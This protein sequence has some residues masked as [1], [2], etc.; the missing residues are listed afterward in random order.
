VNFAVGLRYWLPGPVVRGLY[1]QVGISVYYTVNS[2]V[3]N[4]VSSR[5]NRGIREILG[6]GVEG[7][8]GPREGAWDYYGAR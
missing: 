2:A 3:D 5:E 4:N 6:L 7:G 8:L 1:D